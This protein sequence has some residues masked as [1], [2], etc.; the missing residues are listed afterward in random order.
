MIIYANDVVFIGNSIY[1]INNIKHTLDSTFRIK[2]IGIL[3]YFLVLE[4]AHSKKGI[5][6]CQRKYCLDLLSNS[7]LR[8]SKPSSTP[9][10]SAIHLHQDAGLAIIDVSSYRRLVGQLLYLTTTCLDI[11]F[12]SNN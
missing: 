11:T 3:K 8:G 4:V 9:M 10:D 1:E 2:D 6:L 12:A 5:S 7:G